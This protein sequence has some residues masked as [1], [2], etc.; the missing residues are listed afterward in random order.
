MVTAN[1][2]W[3]AKKGIT[4][5]NY[6]A[7]T[8]PSEPNYIASHGGDYFGMDNDKQSFIDAN[9]STIVD[10]LEEKNIAWGEY[11][12]D[13]PYTGF[14]GSSW[15]NQDSGANDYVR[16]HNPA[17]IYNKNA[18][19]VDRLSVIKNLTL[20]YEDLENDTLPQWMF[21]TPN[22]TSD[23]HDTSVTVAGAWT[24]NFLEPLLNDTRF[25]KNTLVLITFDENSSYAIQNRV[26]A[27]LLGDAVPAHL[28]GTTDSNFYNHYSEIATVEANWD[29]HT[30]GRWDV[31][32]NV[33]SLVAHKTGDVVREWNDTSAPAILDSMYYNQSYD[34]VFNDAASYPI[35]PA[36]NLGIESP[37]G[38][39]VS[40]AIKATW[41]HSSSP[42][43]YSSIVEVPDGL[44][45]PA[46]YGNG[47]H[48]G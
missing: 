9:V 19:Q 38:R 31:G 28:V 13:L 43:Y 17:V 10:L 5:E 47:G 27:I 33:F 40:P 37:S 22:M 46:G 34:G 18:G 7:L 20:F 4:L 25:M 45:P 16:K 15:V 14:E 21:I 26:L 36:P 44:N 39:T 30:L 24:R 1:L 42:D 32:A 2:A 6:F 3:L 8:H 35:Y 48:A 11:Q 29:L 12:E 41:A 23:G